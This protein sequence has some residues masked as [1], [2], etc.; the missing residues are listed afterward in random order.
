M[1]AHPRIASVL[2]MALL[3]VGSFAWTAT[4]PVSTPD[5]QSLRNSDSESLLALQERQYSPR[6]AI[7][8]AL[9][10]I[11]SDV[12]TVG[13]A[14]DKALSLAPPGSDEALLA[15]V[16]ECA[17]ADLMG[18]KI[19]PTLCNE[20]GRGIEQMQEPLPGALAHIYFGI[21]LATNGEHNRAFQ[22]NRLA[23]ERA[24]VAN[25]MALAATT[26]NNQG[27]D[28][29]IRGLPIQ[30]LAKFQSA[31]EHI[32]KDGAVG[33]IALLDTIT[34]NL[35]SAHLDLGDAHAA[36]ELVQ[37]VITRQSYDRNNPV[38]LIGEVILARATLALGRPQE[39]YDRLNGVLGAIG[40]LGVNSLRA[41]ALAVIG[42][43]QIALNQSDEGIASFARAS[44]YAERSGDTVRINQVNVQFAEALVELERFAEA[45]MII[46]KSIGE[47][48][49][50]G[51]SMIL[52]QAL[53]LRADV[54]RVTGEHKAAKET[55]RQARQVQSRVL[56]AEH[57]MNL[58]VLGKSLELANK[59]N[60][61]ANAQRE[62]RISEARAQR[63]ITLR[64]QLILTTLLLALIAYLVLSRRYERK[65]ART[66]QSA[67]ADLEVKVM[68]RTAALEQEMAQRLEAES[69]RQ[70]LAQSLADAE[71]LQAIGQLTSG[72]A[73]DFN[74]L[75]TVVTLSAG[76]LKDAEHRSTGETDQNLENILAAAESASD[77]TASLLAYA[78]KQPLTPEPT[79]L[80]TFLE[81]CQPLFESTLGEGVRLITQVEPC[82]ILVDRSKLT[83]AIINLLLNAKEAMQGHGIARLQVKQ[84]L[85]IDEHGESQQW[86]SIVVSDQGRG[87]SPS[88]LRRATEPF[89]TTKAVGHG[90]GLG[91]S[92]VEGFAKQ[93]GGFLEID[94]AQ[95]EGSAVTLNIPLAAASATPSVEAALANTAIDDLGVA[96]IVDDQEALRNVLGRLLEQM[97]ME[98]LRAS[99]GAEALD[100]LQQTP[101]PK[102]LITDLMM[103]GSMNGQQLAAQVRNR[104]PEVAVLIMSG[105]TDTIELDVE[106][107]HKPFSLDDLRQAISRCVANQRAA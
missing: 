35:A 77:I 73:H 84:L 59:A 93:S 70:S 83:T 29:L 96:L 74:N 79:E 38:N 66:I 6:V 46:N 15:A 81:E 16:L 80:G 60:E 68:E 100:I 3:V 86:A 33:Q 39:A 4:K 11:G 63:E 94:S 47:I 76:L 62:A 67:N 24:L 52:A 61:L 72:V 89:Y 101:R 37:S 56:G 104:Y 40:K 98:T 65:V 85:Q 9:R 10:Q 5:W 2:S 1:T 17:L 92:M 42:E 75:M 13:R 105:Y 23:E 18:V 25:D 20:R 8:I 97:G 64:N 95:W 54:M 45:E 102:L 7:V 53:E 91:L 58:E 49:K 22:A 55:R 106:F 36:D 41:S 51:A 43:L 34:S 19:D 32:R 57:D 78:R 31:L 26:Q 107:L 71:K 14:L 88:Q 90:T 87:M 99:S 82:T 30:A 44:D 12:T 48:E 27:V 21:W 50:R 69:Q 28:Y 103:P